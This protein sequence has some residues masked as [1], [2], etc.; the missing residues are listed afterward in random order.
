MGGTKLGG[1]NWEANQYGNDYTNFG[2]SVNIQICIV[3]RAAGAAIGVSVLSGAAA[4]R[5][6]FLAWSIL[7]IVYAGFIYA[8]LAHWTLAKGWY[9]LNIL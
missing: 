4:E 9:K 3:F 6:T 8:G 7:T 2:I 5:M 1:A